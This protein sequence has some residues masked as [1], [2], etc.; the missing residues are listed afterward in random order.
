MLFNSL[1]YLC[2]LPALVIVYHLCPSRLRVGLLL[3]ASYL[4]YA[5]WNAVYLLLIVGLTA[6]NYGFGLAL[7]RLRA[8]PRALKGMLAG[9]ITVDL[10]V[11]GFYKYSAFLIRSLVSGLGAIHS[12]VHIDE[13]SLILPLGISFF[14][15]E[16]IH[17]LVDVYRGNEVVRS[18]LKFAVFAGFFPT[19]IAGPIKRYENFI[20]QLERRAAVDAVRWGEGARLI[21]LGM[22]KKVAIADNLAPLVGLGF[23]PTPQGLRFADAWLVTIAFALQI[24]FDFSGFT[25][26]ARGS[27]LML[28]FQVP[29]NFR[30]PYLAANVSEFWHR[31]HISLSTW[32]RDY[33]YKPLGGNRKH[34]YRNL[35]LTFLIGG[36]WHGANWTFVIWGAFHG[37][38]LVMYWGT[39]S[40][41]AR[42]GRPKPERSHPIPVLITWAATFAAVCVGWVFF[43]AST[44]DQAIAVLKPMFGFA[45][46]A[47][48]F[49]TGQRELIIAVLIGCLGVE[50]VVEWR[51]RTVAAGRRA[52]E[53]VARLGALRWHLQPAAWVAL[54][55]ITLILKPPTGPHF[56]YFQF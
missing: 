54:A 19:Q 22:F 41:R 14:T 35:M 42:L 3:G 11:L 44:F 1:Q 39:V 33:L 29:E 37:G 16:F 13:P 25:D 32:L 20:P 31:W 9:A 18:P 53:R 52:G 34:R 51:E 47:G 4:F 5:S 15:F 55:A 21:V 43:R 38:L 56:I 50:A 6:A 23:G 49:T 28:G 26:I 17:Y 2:F 8:R 24:Y 40:V 12:G 10:G 36:L 7:G 46:G 45:R 48:V 27:A 30:R